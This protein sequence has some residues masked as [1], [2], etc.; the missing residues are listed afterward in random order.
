MS[1]SY[2]L[3]KN[4]RIPLKDSRFHKRQSLLIR[5]PERKAGIIEQIGDVEPTE[6]MKPYDAAGAYAF[7]AFCDM[8]CTLLEPGLDES[9]SVLSSTVSAAAGGYS[10]LLVCDRDFKRF[11]DTDSFCRLIFA[12]PYDEIGKADR[13]DEAVAFG[14]RLD[15]VLPDEEQLYQDREKAKFVSDIN[16]PIDDPLLLLNVMRSC[17]EQGRIFYTRCSDQRLEKNGVIAAGEV[18]RMLGV[19]GIPESAEEIAAAKCLILA[20]ETGC[21]LHITQVSTKG[22]VELIREAK[23]RGVHVTCDTSPLYFSMNENDILYYGTYAKVIPPLRKEESRIA[24]AEGLLDGTI[25][26]IST[27][28]RPISD[29]SKRRSIGKAEPGAVG[30]QTAFS[31]AVSYLVNKYN[32]GIGRLAELMAANPA[33]ILGI[34]GHTLKEGEQA[35]IVI[36]D[37]SKEFIVT[38]SLLKSRSSNT[39]FLGLTL[40]G[41]TLE[42][43]ICGVPQF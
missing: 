11:S 40:N 4:A 8:N 15:K 21:R 13:L 27:A 16:S 20:K 37:P 41:I 31:A 38:K 25:D 19:M 34:G 10:A 23:A 29:A 2:L 28:H 42:T 7:P 3:I 14:A 35:D 17:A 36:C 33:K 26:C 1:D 12:L 24:V 9:R 5:K 22:T 6:R 18:S 43:F 39:P 32:L 30:F